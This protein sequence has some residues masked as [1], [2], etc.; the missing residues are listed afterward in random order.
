MGA[1]QASA[2]KGPA[3]AGYAPPAA[4]LA[5]RARADGYMPPLA[6]LASIPARAVV[7]R[8]CGGCGGDE[9]EELPVQPRLEVGPVGDRFE[10]EADAI[11]T[12]V[13]AMRDS[14]PAEA[15][16][17]VVQRA[18]G[19]CSTS[20]DEPRARRTSLLGEE[21]SEA[22]PAIMR[23][24]L[25]G[26]EISETPPMIQRKCAACAASE[27]PP[28][29][30]RSSATGAKD[31]RASRDD[32]GRARGR[33]EGGGET[34][35]A[36]HSQLTS[37]GSPLPGDTRTFFEGRLGRDLGGVRVHQGSGALA[38]NRSIAARAFTYRDHIWLGAGESAGPSFTMA[39]ELAHVMQQTAPGP[40]GR[41]EPRVQRADCQARDNLFF[42]PKK[43]GS[44]N[45]FHDATSRWV[46]KQDAA[47]IGEVRV[48]NYAKSGYTSV[49]EKFGFA[50]LVRTDNGNLVGMGFTGTK[51]IMDPAPP[52]ANPAAAPSSGPAQ[53]PPVPKV[54]AQ[55]LWYT[56]ESVQAG[57][58]V[59][60]VNLSTYISMFGGSR[61]VTRKGK[62][63]DPITTEKQMDAKAA[64]R[65]QGTDFMR[66]A[67]TAPGDIKV[68]E[69]KFGGGRDL[70]PEARAQA[71]NY[72]NGFKSAN[73]GY[74]KL[75]ER[76]ARAHTG[77]ND[78]AG[79]SSN[80][81]LAPWTLGADLMSTWGG[82]A[83][84]Q[85]ISETQDLV[86]AKWHRGWLNDYSISPCGNTK[87][88]FQGKL[89]A[90]HDAANP[91][92]WLYAFQ[93][94]DTTGKFG[95]TAKAAFKPHKDV[96]HTLETDLLAS[97]TDKDKVVKRPLDGGAATTPAGHR[98]AARPAPRAVASADRR[99]LARAKPAKPIPAEDFFAKNYESWKAKQ[100][101]LTEDFG[102]FEKSAAG[103]SATGDLLFDTAVRNTID[104]TGSDPSG[105]LT[106]HPSEGD[107]RQDRDTLNEVELMSG[108]SGRVL[109]ML[110]KTF[111]TAFVK[112][113]NVYRGL[114][115]KFDDFMKNRKAP[116]S[117]GGKL[118]AAVIK[119]AAKIFAAVLRYLLP[120]IGHLLISCVERGFK[121][122]IEKWIG[123]DIQALVGEKI[124][125]FKSKVE[126]IENDI[127]TRV[128][129]AL[130]GI[131]TWL[132][133]Q[134][135]S[136]LKV[137]DEVGKLIAIARTAFNAARVAMCAAGGLE[138]IGISCVVAGVDFVLSLFDVSPAEALAGALLSTCVAQKL[139][140]E[141]ILVIDTIRNLPAI[142]AQKILDF[143]RPLLPTEPVNIA[144]LL[145]DTIAG[146]PEMPE[147]KEVT[148]GEGGSD[149]ATP[150]GPGWGVPPGVDP[151]VLNRPATEDEVKR[152]G[153]LDRS[154]D[155]TAAAT[156]PPPAPAQP[157]GAA[158]GAGP[159]G[160]QKEASDAVGEGHLGP[161]A[162]LTGINLEVHGGF[163]PKKSYD[164]K[165]AYPVQLVAVAS[166]ASEYGPVNVEIFVHAIF[167]TGSQWKITYTFRV[168]KA[169][170]NIVLSDSKTC[171][172]LE[173]H[174]SGTKKF[175][176]P[177]RPPTAPQT[178]PLKE[179]AK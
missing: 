144:G 34:I 16:P 153:T 146:Q 46:T 3:S 23:T 61:G 107:Q 115:Q 156:P 121:A 42:F 52:T 99:G 132:H 17:A 70:A 11:A 63:Y 27:D 140:A 54:S 38:L 161:A 47:I 65:W 147:V 20:S 178:A 129:N 80:A 168:K 59:K 91:F 25:V 143:V 30:R 120:Q 148:C 124:E 127:Q 105:R 49:P 82:P 51:P 8:A 95:S 159:G 172:R 79:K 169:G 74:E 150:T 92:L 133:E 68:G 114:K 125:E 44:I 98:V 69:I 89:F 36:S 96:A 117:K 104:I 90:Q 12:Q 6:S 170:E 64:P 67:G 50:D 88:S 179:G 21:L 41:S 142:I 109:G 78:I 31:E 111:G 101:K 134:Y 53:D 141:N 138:T 45:D 28:R 163:N 18:C 152:H 71:T 85:P 84:W 131:S 93:A 171:E 164:G 13:M 66:D 113:I 97:P 48:P 86:I 55:Q 166:D 4:L 15:A 72:V 22:A 173:I 174:G 162:Q 5:E 151:K 108:L 87:Q 136:I 33:R 122:A 75:R 139:I 29:A 57:G 116:T 1:A 56:V 175:T 126:Q 177:L 10:Q 123:A 119:V 77:A 103:Q 167:K 81:S 58:W 26:E 110:R 106:K 137:W 19:A 128:D 102:G 32:G 155:K 2:P 35:A 14:G 145:C 24:S 39:H 83:G 94:G 130:G 43:G 40:L 149:S 158:P 112:V 160:E 135:E 60:P 9:A 62:S 165:I 7:Q 100:L 118:A 154:A 157:P 176:S 76:N 73:K 37:G